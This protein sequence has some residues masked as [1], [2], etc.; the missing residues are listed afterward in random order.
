MSKKLQG[1]VSLITGGG[2]GIG[3][4]TA[5]AFAAEGASLAVADIREEAARA[6][7]EELRAAGAKAIAITVDVSKDA[8][9]S[10]MVNQVVEHF[11]R[12]DVAFN[13]AAI[14]VEHEPLAKT[15]E[16]MFDRLMSVNVKGVWLCMKY[17]IQQ[18]LKQGGG[19]IVNT[20]SIGGLIAAP[21][22]PIYGATKHAVLGLTKSAAVEYGRKGIRVNAVCPGVIRTEMTERA[23]ALEPRRAEHL[24]PGHPIGRIGEAED[25]A[26]A[27]VFLASDDASFMLGHAL[28]VDGGFTAR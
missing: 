27:V 25:I 2:A 9:V 11:G 26:R 13:N 21:R 18:M 8:Q 10:A 7:C 22:Q 16:E 17:E 5:L 12:L 15:S 19:A 28:T 3:R 20:S 24:V 23:L 1:K 4:A 6:V 14:E